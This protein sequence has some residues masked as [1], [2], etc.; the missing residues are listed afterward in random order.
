ML[1][2]PGRFYR[3]AFAGSPL[4]ARAKRP[5]R[6]GGTMP[7]QTTVARRAGVKSQNSR[8]NQNYYAGNVGSGVC[9]RSQGLRRSLWAL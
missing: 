1:F 8:M 2:P 3:T 5:F 7:F 6:G 9:C 4:A